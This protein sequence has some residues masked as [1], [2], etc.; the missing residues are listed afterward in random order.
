MQGAAK[1]AVTPAGV[2]ASAEPYSRAEARSR[3]ALVTTVI[4]IDWRLFLR[5]LQRETQRNLLVAILGGL[6]LVNLTM[7][8]TELGRLMHHA[9]NGHSAP[10]SARIL[11]IIAWTAAATAFVFAFW[12]GY[13]STSARI[14]E[15]LRLYGRGRGEVFLSGIGR[16]LFGRQALVLLMILL[17]IITLVREWLPERCLVM[18]AALFILLAAFSSAAAAF[19]FLPDKVRAGAL[20]F[21]FLFGGASVISPPSR[22]LIARAA[23]FLPPAIVPALIA[24]GPLRTMVWFSLLLVFLGSMIG[25]ELLLAS[26]R[27][28]A[29]QFAPAGALARALE[30]ILSSRRLFIVLF[31]RDLLHALRWRRLLGVWLLSLGIVVAFVLKLSP[32]RPLLPLVALS[33]V[34]TLFLSPFFSN[35]FGTDGG[36]FQT[37]WIL[38]L[39]PEKIM[40]AKELS[41]L[42]LALLSLAIEWSV[43]LLSCHGALRPGMS[44]YVVCAA[45]GFALWLAAAG[46]VTSV[47]FPLGSN[48]REISGDYLSPAAILATG[49]AC[50]LFFLFAGGGAMLFDFRRIGES[51]LILAGVLILA[52]AIIAHIVLAR[53]ATR[54]MKHRREEILASLIAR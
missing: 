38:P 5:G 4:A 52:A 8:A 24:S 21:L 20:I 22:L 48:P 51:A 50:G 44:L 32:Q 33:L 39:R 17:P 29:D 47:L 35:S 10:V 46:R 30:P 2:S 27:E 53:A 40:L 18:T 1:K 37:Y 13:V 7:S 25:L 9:A 26:R 23:H 45:F 14:S 16:S 41:L 15:A 42:C 43:V 49:F 11:F 12:S 36:G 54:I 31:A 34:T 28:A 6:L 19:R 3:F